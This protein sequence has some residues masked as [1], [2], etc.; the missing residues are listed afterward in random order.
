[1]ADSG[2]IDILRGALH[3]P[4]VWRPFISEGNSQ[5]PGHKALATAPRADRNLID[6]SGGVINFE[7]RRSQKNKR[8]AWRRFMS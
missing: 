7:R 3:C 2:K 8:N 4:A 6:I 5:F 1:M